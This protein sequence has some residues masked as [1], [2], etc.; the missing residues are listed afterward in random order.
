MSG[1][2]IG[3]FIGLAFSGWLGQ[4]LY[5][6]NSAYAVIYMAIAELSGILPLIL[7]FH[8]DNFFFFAKNTTHLVPTLFLLNL[9]A[10][11]LVVQTGT[12][13]RSVLQNVVQPTHRS[14]AFAIFAIFDDLGKG[15]GPVVVAALVNTLNSRRRAFT[16]ATCFGWFVGA[17]INALVAFT[18]VAD[19]TRLASAQKAPCCALTQRYA[20]YFLRK[21][22]PRKP[23]SPPSSFTDD[24]TASP[25]LELPTYQKP[26]RR[27]DARRHGFSTPNTTGLELVDLQSTSLQ[28]SAASGPTSPLENSKVITHV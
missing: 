21:L 2:G 15:G 24:T 8:I 13:V 6:I 20:T 23:S 28:Q 17:L 25:L 12:V 3:T 1:F 5:N 10:G 4:L 7:V 27:S 22:S 18:V 11:F 16:L 19:E 26:S 14:L 9:T